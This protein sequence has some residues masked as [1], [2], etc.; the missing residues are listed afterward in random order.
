MRQHCVPFIDRIN[1]FLGY[2]HIF[3]WSYGSLK[4]VS[5]RPNIGKPCQP[6]KELPKKKKLLESDLRETIF[7]FIFQFLL[8]FYFWILLIPISLLLN[9][10]IFLSIFH[11][12]SYKDSSY[13]WLM[14]SALV[15]LTITISPLIACLMITSN[16]SDHSSSSGNGRML[17]TSVKV[18]VLVFLL[19]FKCAYN[20]VQF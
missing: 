9:L 1:V 19:V 11:F 16:G 15:V 6:Q 17:I 5:L 12:S 2:L 13:D 18:T 10:K 20:L 14:S 3:Q 7:W 8:K 4:W